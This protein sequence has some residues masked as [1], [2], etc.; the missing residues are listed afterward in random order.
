MTLG[1]VNRQTKEKEWEGDETPEIRESESEVWSSDLGSYLGFDRNRE[2]EG[3]KCTESEKVK[4][5]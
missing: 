3:A 4:E 2:R 1:E 5:G